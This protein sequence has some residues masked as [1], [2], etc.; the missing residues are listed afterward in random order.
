MKTVNFKYL[1][2]RDSNYLFADDV[3]KEYRF[4]KCRKDL[5]ENYKLN[6]KDYIGNWFKVKYFATKPLSP[7]DHNNEILIISDLAILI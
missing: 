4:N 6:N 1:G 2:Y 5:I 3:G 7:N